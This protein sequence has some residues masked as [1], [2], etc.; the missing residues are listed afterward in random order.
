MSTRS[1]F[2]NPLIRDW[3]FAGIFLPDDCPTEVSTTGSGPF[4]E[5]DF[6]EFLGGL[7]ITV[8]SVDSGNEVLVVGNDSWSEED[9]LELL[10]QRL[11]MYLKVYSQEMFLC[12]L[13]T[14]QDP[15]EETDEAIFEAFQ[16][17]HGALEFLAQSGFDWPSTYVTGGGNT[18]PDIYGPPVGLLR[19]MGYRVG[20]SGLLPSVRRAILRK[21]FYLDPLPKIDSRE[22]IESWGTAG[23]A[24]RLHKIADCIAS[25]AKLAKRRQQPPEQA[26][27]D[28]ESDLAWLRQTFYT[29]RFRFQWPSTYIW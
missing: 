19:Y 15:F 16:E 8:Y 2:H 21:V 22:Y 6:D 1:P 13:A 11:G 23:S 4:E 7:G 24:Q 20:T 26:I 14:Q 5:S 27:E 12:Y 28:W 3:F 10:D 29:G 25:F 17:G 9:L 18:T